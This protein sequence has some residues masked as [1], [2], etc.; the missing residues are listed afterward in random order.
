MDCCRGEEV[1]LLETEFLPFDDV[2]GG[3][4]DLGDGFRLHFLFNGA[5]IVP[6]VEKLQV[7]ITA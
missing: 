2:I 4:E 5:D 7:K 3:V 6:L 1:F